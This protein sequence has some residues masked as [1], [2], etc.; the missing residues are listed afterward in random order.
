MANPFQFNFP[1]GGAF[2][3]IRLCTLFGIPIL[4]RPSLVIMLILFML[5][6]GSLFTGLLYAAMLLAGITGHELAHALVA[7]RFGCPTQNISLSLLGGCASLTRLPRRPL[8]EFLV[9]IAG[10]AAS[11]AFAALALLAMAALSSEGGLAGAAQYAWRA[12]WGEATYYRE[13]RGVALFYDSRYTLDSFFAVSTG[14]LGIVD[15]FL[16]AACTNLIL[17]LFNLLP[18]FPMDGGRVFR[19]F[20]ANFT[21]RE[22]ATFYAMAV[23]RVVAVCLGIL[24]LW[25]FATGSSWGVVTCLIAYMIWQTGYQ[26]YMS[27]L[28]EEIYNPSSWRY[29]RVSPPPYGGSPSDAEIGRM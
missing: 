15:A 18:G 24:G 9:A 27:V 5:N 10:P 11:F 3:Q 12:F 29:A 7:R 1:G 22:R 21:S 14:L 17:G 28:A 4:M 2:G 13:L 26:E 8:K 23:G 16:Y 25:R 19:S 20:M 6:T